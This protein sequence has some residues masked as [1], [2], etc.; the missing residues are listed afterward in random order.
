M[1]AS[2]QKN[3]AFELCFISVSIHQAF[4]MLLYLAVMTD[5]SRDNNKKASSLT[6]L[7]TPH[8]RLQFQ[9]RFELRQHSIPSWLYSV[10]S[11]LGPIFGG[12]DYGAN[13]AE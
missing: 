6:R 3:L 7:A 8:P 9:G 4:L 12:D 2:D 13:D 1:T 11:R 10:S 5:D